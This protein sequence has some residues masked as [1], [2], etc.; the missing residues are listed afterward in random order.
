MFIKSRL[1]RNNV[2]GS[3]TQTVE[4]NTEV[5][6]KDPKTTVQTNRILFFFCYKLHQQFSR[7]IYLL[8][9]QKSE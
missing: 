8:V 1:G 7:N 2:C 4:D 3:P 6:I 5:P 9:Q